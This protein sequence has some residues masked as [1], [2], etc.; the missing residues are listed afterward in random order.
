M[1][2]SLDAIR[3]L[4]IISTCA[5][6]VTACSTPP[7]ANPKD[8]WPQYRGHASQSQT[9]SMPAGVPRFNLIWKKATAGEC[10]A[11]VA[12]RDGLVIMPDQGDGK[13]MIRALRLK[14]GSEQWHYAYAN[15]NSMQFTSAPRSTPLIYDN[16]VYVMNAYGNSMCLEL[17]TGRLLWRR[18]NDT[19]P[20]VW[21]FCP[22]PFIFDG[23]L[24]LAGSGQ[25]GAIAAFEP[26]SGRPVWNAKDAGSVNYANFLGGT[27]GGIAQVIGYDE[28]SLGGWNLSSGERL[29][30]MEIEAGDGYLCIVPTALNDR[31]VLM[32]PAQSIRIHRFRPDGTLN[33]EHDASSDA[34][35]AETSSPTIFG[36]FIFGSGQAL[37]CLDGG[38]ALET[39]WSYE[40]ESLYGEISV[41][42]AERRLL[43][44]CDGYAVMLDYDRGK[45]E[46]IA[47][48]KVCEPTFSLPA[49]A[50]GK[51]IVRDKNFVYCYDLSPIHP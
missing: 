18:E 4:T 8:D 22:S 15:T 41:I 26:L 28:T 12:V 36:D 14:D 32:S 43:A 16:K 5:V 42:A 1:N 23:K 48:K 20:P 11:G 3:M 21:G 31:L 13:D 19:P 24:L 9:T 25:S 45:V 47:S 35:Y 2:R 6:L 49:V 39:L 50:Q 44:F 40:D 38:N 37:V 7:H 10:H 30:H 51:L 29:W 34:V 46:K 27:F 33:P 17:K